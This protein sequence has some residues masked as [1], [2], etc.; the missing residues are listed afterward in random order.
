MKNNKILRFSVITGFLFGAHGL[1]FTQIIP[2][3]ARVG[4][5]A[6]ERGLILGL[7]ALLAMLAQIMV[8]NLCNKLG[9]LKQILLVT[10]LFAAGASFAF[11]VFDR[12]LLPYHLAIL[13]IMG[14]MTRV[15]DSLMEL[16]VLE[17][18]ELYHD[19]GLIRSFGS[20]G[21]AVGAFISGIIVLRLDFVWLSYLCI[22]ITLLSFAL[23]SSTPD[24]EIVKRE[25][26]SY[27]DSLAM[28]RNYDFLLLIVIFFMIQ[29]VYS[30]DGI[31]V[32]DY[33][34]HLGGNAGDVGVRTA[35]SAFSEIP[36]FFLV[37]RFLKRWGAKHLTV[38]SL[39]MMA[40]KFF[41]YALSANVPSILL[42]TLLQSV[43]FPIFLVTQ[44][45]LIYKVSPLDLRASAQ[46]LSIA[47]TGSFASV[48][49]PIV[50]GL[51][52][53]YLGINSIFVFYALIMIVALGLMARYKTRKAETV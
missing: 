42:I 21:W 6:F 19:F 50:T 39:A 47:L 38:F 48:L 22:L 5:N 8:G 32:V 2:F 30:A 45:D 43:T 31:L 7:Y 27:R 3:L 18:K 51:L 15:S 44:R 25:S 46:M 35:L 40:L 36:M 53:S 52:L 26:M 10:I 24:A 37:N 9:K 20:L 14:G 33:I 23:M 13:G 41:L 12:L 16:W 4:Y 34:Y 11:Y 28:L 49:A 17:T 29:F 1:I